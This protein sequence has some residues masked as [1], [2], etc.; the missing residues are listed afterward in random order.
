MAA[1]QISS[2]NNRPRR[3]NPGLR[4]VFA[5]SGVGV[6]LYGPS[7]TGNLV[8]NNFILHNQAEGVRVESSNNTIGEALDGGGNVISGNGTQ[9]VLITGGPNVQGNMVLGNLIGTDLGIA[10]GVRRK[11]IDALP[12]L[13]QGVLIFD[14]PKNTIGGTTDDARNVIGG[15]NGD[16]LIILGP[17]ASGNRVLGNWVGFNIV[18]GLESLF[19]PNQNGIVIQ[20]PGNFIG[21]A[22]TGAGN[23]IDNNRAHGLLITGAASSGNTVQG[24]IIGLN[25]DGGSAF[26]NAL[27]GIHVEGAPDTVIGGT[28]V[29]ARN[30]ISSNNNGIVIVGA[31]ATGNRIMGNFIGTATDGATDLGNAV[32]GILINGASVNTIGGTAAGA[33]NV[34]SGNNRG[35]HI[36]GATAL[37][38]TIQGNFIGTDLTGTLILNNEVDGILIDGQS[39]NNL[40]GG[41]L[42]GASNVIAFNAGNGVL[43]DSG[44]DNAIRANSIHDNHDLGIA[45]NAAQ[46][47]NGNIPAPVITFAAPSGTAT[48]VQ[49]TFDAT[50]ATSYTIEF[51]SSST[52]DLTGYGEGETFLSRTVVTTDALG[53]ASFNLNVPFAVPSGHYVTATATS[54]TGSTSAFSN[55]MIA[56]PVQLQ[57]ATASYT[58]NETDGTLLV[59]I[60][61][62]GGMGGTVSIDYATGGGNAT[63][64]VDYTTIQGTLYFN[65]GDPITKSF[66][67]PILNP[68][69]VGGSVTFDINLSNPTGGASVGSP[70]SATVTIIGNAVPSVSFATASASVRESNGSIS[71]TVTRNSTVGTNTVDYATIAGTAVPGLNYTT[72]AGTLTFAP[73]VASQTITIPVLSDNAVHGAL[74]F[75]VALSNPS[76]AVLAA[77]S[78]ATVTI[79][80]DDTP[81]TLGLAASTLSTAPS[82]ATAQISVLR[83]G[84]KAGTVTLDFAT[85][86]GNAIPGIDYLP[87]SGTLTFGPGETSKTISVPLLNNTIPGNDVSFPLTIS[88]AGGGATLGA[89]RTIVVTVRHPATAGGSLANDHTPPIIND[90]LP[91]VGSGGVVALSIGFSEPMT[92]NRA[93]DQAN[94]AYFVT[95]PGPDGVIG[96]Y[97]DGSTPITSLSYNAATQHALLTFQSP[98]AFGTFYQL[99]LSRYAGLVPGRGLTDLAGNLLDGTGTGQAPATPYVTT[100]AVARSLTYRDRLNDTVTLTLSGS[101]LLSLQR[102][103]NGDATALRILNPSP[104]AS[105]TGSVRRPNRRVTGPVVIPSIT[106]ATGVRVRLGSPF[107]VGSVSARA[108]DTLATRGKFPV[109][110][111]LKRLS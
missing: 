105:L 14:S 77:P 46:S 109:V 108:V 22:I 63:P 35:V 110:G 93:V 55:A 87:V 52:T 69:K 29:A 100:F 107:R 23:T 103:S 40:I 37:N 57:L 5:N 65:P 8:Q 47:A 50:P 48:T 111:A 85:G 59:S 3:G 28:V 80:D 67:I 25:P 32:D 64:G 76:G 4:N 90:F 106:G 13:L 78:T 26:G 91:V 83:T 71:L 27:D 74:T 94:Y 102:G 56:V 62:S 21:G 20:A 99:V 51:F 97:D 41:T 1:V 39:S 73:G 34:I 42:A 11:G 98:L 6:Y 95:S 58:V 2:S 89:I 54:G 81:G 61:R 92:P 33:G 30:V 72:R 24:N 12:N 15:N 66:N 82:V 18:D 79:A 17:L 53:H 45:L 36:T 60:T 44:T 86:A 70:G 43:I 16:G 9:G 49:G 7:G 96:T 75:T 38:N 10:G 68:N 104:G 88:S 31:T 101:G 84:G 19:I